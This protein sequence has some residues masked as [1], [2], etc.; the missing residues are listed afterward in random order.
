LVVEEVVATSLLFISKAWAVWGMQAQKKKMP[1]HP[2]A[3][4]FSVSFIRMLRGMCASN[5]PNSVEKE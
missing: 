4:D 1:T 3:A 5:Q 2:T